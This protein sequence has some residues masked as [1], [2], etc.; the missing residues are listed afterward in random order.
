[1]AARKLLAIYPFTELYVLCFY[2]F[3]YIIKILTK[4]WA[5]SSGKM[6]H[7]ILQILKLLTLNNSSTN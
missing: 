1:M 5:V 7:K 2:T 3:M 6:K 4:Y